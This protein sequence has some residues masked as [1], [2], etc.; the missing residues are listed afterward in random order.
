A[1]REV[2]FAQTTRGGTAVRRRGGPDPDHVPGI[3]DDVRDHSLPAVER[4]RVEGARRHPERPLEF[5]AYRLR[6]GDELRGPGWIALR[7]DLAERAHRRD[8]VRLH[9]DGGDRAV[10]SFALRVEVAVVRILPDLIFD[11]GLALPLELYEEIAVAI[12]ARSHPLQ[13][14]A[15][16]WL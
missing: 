8:R 10:G 16:I 12:A 11:P 5:L 14:R 13:R 6:A 9:L 15:D 1:T 4:L 3:R 2:S 7:H